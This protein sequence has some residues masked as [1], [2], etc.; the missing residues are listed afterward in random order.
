MQHLSWWHLSIPPI[1]NQILTK[2]FGAN[3]LG[4]KHFFDQHFVGPKFWNTK[5]FGPKI[6]LGQK[7][8]LDPIF[9]G[10][11]I[12]LD[13]KFYH[14]TNSFWPKI[15]W[16]QNFLNTQIFGHKISLH[17]N[18]FWLIRLTFSCEKNG[19]V[20]LFFCLLVCLI[21]YHLIF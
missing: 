1:S 4:V 19:N 6:I 12:I 15:F 2:L 11:K 14:N 10:P 8:S 5:L 9:I 16:T 18:F 7:F 20:T 3:F 21:V 17:P 13:P